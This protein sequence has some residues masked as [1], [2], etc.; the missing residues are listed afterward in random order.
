MMVVFEN[1]KLLFLAPII[2]AIMILVIR[3]DFIKLK[4][5]RWG[6][7]N[8][9]KTRK[10]LIILALRSLVVIALVVALAQPTVIKQELSSG[11]PSLTILVD[12]SKS[13]DL[14]DRQIAQNL[15]EE[16]ETQIPVRM[17][18][19]GSENSSGIGDELIASMLGNDN[20]LLISDGRVTKGRILG[21]VMVV[22]S[23]I[24]STINVL[25]VSPI[26]K[27]LSVRVEGPRVTTVGIDNE[28]QVRVDETS[29]NPGST[30]Y[31]VIVTIDG[32]EVIDETSSG[33]QGFNF[34]RRLTEG[35]HKITARINAKDSFPD[36]NIFH[37]TVKVEKK[38]KV[39]LITDSNSPLEGMF[40][41][42]YDLSTDTS[43]INTNLKGFSAVVLNDIHVNQIDET[44]LSTFID[45]GNGLVV[46]GGRNSYDKG[47]YK[48]TLF[49]SFLPV[50]VG[51]GEDGAKKFVNVVVL[52]DISGST[53]S[54]FGSGSTS[55]VEDVEKALAIGLV[56][57]LRPQDKVGVIAF[58]VDAYTVAE[59]ERLSANRNVILTRIP[60]LVYTGSTLISE[61][62]RGARNM[63]RDVEGSKNIVLLS[64]GKSGAMEE[65][66]KGAEYAIAQG[67]KVYTVGV[68]E[69]TNREHM[70][71]IASKG[72][73]IYFEPTEAQQLKIIFG[74]S[75]QAPT[76]K[77]KIEKLNNNHF[78]TRNV[79]IS[80]RVS[81]FNQVVPKPNA[82][83]LVATSE[84]RPLFSVW[85]FGLG[86]IAAV[87]TD[88]GSG[89]APQL[90]NKDNTVLIT[91][92]VNWAIGDLSRNKDFDVTI[93]DTFFGEKFDVE[94]ISN[95]MPKSDKM[96]FS[97]VG[98]RLYVS[99][100][101]PAKVGWYSFFDATAATNY[102]LELLSTGYNP[103]LGTL[104]QVTGG[105]TFT[106][107]QTDELIKKVR[108]DSRR[109]VTT[110][111]SLAWIPLVMALLIFLV[112]I[113]IRRLWEGAGKGKR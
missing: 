60:R 47:D 102:P 100:F 68:G 52:I 48:G 17:R 18:T 57:D 61:G 104:V 55:T 89:W 30:S 34:N 76:D 37:K 12:N 74:S 39:L 58:N 84:N 83:V 28:F 38:P 79:K 50:N 40:S 69:S 24:N 85:R 106:E 109:L 88:D 26:N 107:D 92:T 105:S 42:L 49:E 5:T 10:R 15:K 82:D 8:K 13:F 54:G 21:D 31:N 77:L 96:S 43:I 11:N 35:Y 64:D 66:L 65:D 3:R 86:R 110:P 108:E 93:R 63:L 99:E 80:G 53:G 22:A 1:P 97:K 25:S 78:I 101:R 23:S 32:E 94:V 67:M 27:D 56:K 6:S 46:F 73:G 2:I 51:S 7:I 4:G 20:I 14:F 111:K 41:Q 75:E 44:K 103:E 91:R 45:D 59:M 81:G 112:D 71:A 98:E 62:L 113:A 87:T 16:L 36:N 19:I 95:T 90:L 72:G 9:N 29:P 70:Q 33:T